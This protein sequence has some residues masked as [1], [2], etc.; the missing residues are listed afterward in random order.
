MQQSGPTIPGAS[1]MRHCRETVEQGLSSGWYARRVPC[2]VICGAAWVP[3]RAAFAVS[4]TMA[5][6]HTLRSSYQA[7]CHVTCHC[8]ASLS[9][10]A[11]AHPARI[12]L[13]YV[14]VDRKG[15]QRG[16]GPLQQVKEYVEKELEKLGYLCLLSAS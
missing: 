10:V 5:E 13:Q 4:V 15:R 12:P 3:S 8:D 6:Q 1:A 2:V 16:N 14:K 11:P 9:K 7:S